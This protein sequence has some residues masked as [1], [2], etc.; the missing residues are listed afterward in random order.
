MTDKFR[1]KNAPL[2]E[3]VAE[4]TWEL[5]R[6]STV[7]GGAIDPLYEDFAEA[8]IEGIKEKGYGYTEILAM[9]DEVPLELLGGQPVIR[10]RKNMKSW[11]V[12]QIGPGYFSINTSS[13]YYGW[14]SFFPLIK[15]GLETLFETYPLSSKKLKVSG[16]KIEYVNGFTA[17]HGV[18]K[19]LDFVKT[20]LSIDPG[21]NDSV[22]KKFADPEKD[23]FYVSESHMRLK[24]LPSSKSIIRITPGF[25]RDDEDG[26]DKAVI[27]NFIVRVEDE[28]SPRTCKE[29]LEWFE[30]AH[31][32][33]KSLFES[34]TSDSLKKTMGPK[35]PVA[36]G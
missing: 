18:N 19:Y 16:V 11:P 6:L 3:V 35:I 7:P 21:L 25:L 8:F 17:K 15:E 22:M 30:N 12:F 10:C 23:F 27:G 1:Y 13:E 24:D 14:E 26:L 29:I 9:I 32:I 5:T 34:I 33:Q 28:D 31:S 2:V 20:N 36:G 4:V